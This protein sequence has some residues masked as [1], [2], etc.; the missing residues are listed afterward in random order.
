[1]APTVVGSARA[2]RFVKEP[3]FRRSASATVTERVGRG[4]SNMT[5]SNRSAATGRF[6]NVSTDQSRPS[7]TIKQGV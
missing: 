7:T 5:T 3:M 6:V 4:T 1:M 2:G